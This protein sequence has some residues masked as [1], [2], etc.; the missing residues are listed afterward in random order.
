VRERV[1]VDA[2]LALVDDR[3]VVPMQ[4]LD[5]ILDR[6]DVRGAR[7]V[8]V[9]DHRRQGRRLAAAGRA[10]NEH[11]PALFRGDLLQHLRQRQLVD[12]GNAHRD[13]AED[14]PDGAALLKRVAAE[15]TEP[16]HAVGEVDLV[17]VLELFAVAGR[18]DRGG[19]RHHV[20]VIEAFFFGGRRQRAADPHHRVA[21]HLQVEVRGAA[22][23]GDFQEV[24]D[25]HALIIGLLRFL[26]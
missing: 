2:N 19:H 5:R 14:H 3:P 25:V 8:D 16:R 17:V 24:I 13:D 23:D 21:A 9:V 6:H 4:I 7:G 26:M 10:G 15:P 1:G 18:Q 20:L 12:R 22:L 11:Q